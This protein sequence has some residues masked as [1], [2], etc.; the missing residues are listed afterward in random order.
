M[1]AVDTKTAERRPLRFHSVDELLAEVNRLVAADKAGKLRHTGNWTLGQALGH[2]AAWIDYGYEGYP[3]GKP[4]WF[5]RVVLKLMKKKY[6]RDGMPGGVKIPK[7]AEGTFGTE[8][9]S[10]EEG[11]ARLKKALVRMQAEEPKYPSP[12]WGHMPRDE[13]IAINLRHAE[14]HLSYFHP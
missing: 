8:V 2:L 4:P 13:R 6:L 9:M 14:L 5:V 3:L 7:T 12:A 10:A 11:A 1:S